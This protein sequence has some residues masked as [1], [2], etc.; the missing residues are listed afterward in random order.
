[1]S[2]IIFRR[3][4]TGFLGTRTTALEWLADHSGLE[5]VTTQKPT[6]T[7]SVIAPKGKVKK[8]TIP[9]VIDILNEQLLPQKLLLVRRTNS[10]TILST[11]GPIDSALLP[12]IEVGDLP[13]RGETELV[14]LIP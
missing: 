5:V 1:M 3:M 14:T 4:R 2:R 6:G 8:Y 13:N 9:Q 12:R 11:A 10:F 7:V